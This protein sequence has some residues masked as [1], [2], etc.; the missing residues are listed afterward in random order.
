M[1]AIDPPAG[2][3]NSAGDGNPAVDDGK[4]DATARS[5]T[6][7]FREHDAHHPPRQQAW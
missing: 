2:C 1:G 7:A 6:Q 3:Q 5:W 4:P